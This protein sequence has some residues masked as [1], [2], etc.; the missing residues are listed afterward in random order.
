M[1]GL[2]TLA[3]RLTARADKRPWH[4][5]DFISGLLARRFARAFASRGVQLPRDP[6]RR[7]FRRPLRCG[8]PTRL[9]HHV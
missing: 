2:S 7:P 4:P 5:L 6:P 8:V 3:E 1:G 9:R